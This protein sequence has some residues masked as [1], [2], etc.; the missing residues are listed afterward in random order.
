MTTIRPISW[1]FAS[2]LSLLS[3]LASASIITYTGALAPEVPGATGTGHVSLIFDDTTNELSIDTTFSGLS[4]TTTVAHIHCCTAAPFTGTV[5]VA[6]TPGTLPGFPVGVSAGSY[7][8]IVDLDLASSFTASFVTNFGGGTLPGAIDALFAGLDA[9]KAYFNIH[10]STFG[11]G[12]IRAFPQQLPE[13]ASLLLA[14]LGLGSLL[15]VRAG[16]RRG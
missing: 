8:T 10:T 7:S 13:P 12:E 3:T 6:V 16:R 14:A 5:G 9:G 2:A 15:Q 4:G 11:G 1:L